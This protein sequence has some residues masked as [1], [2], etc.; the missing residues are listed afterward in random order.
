MSCAI[1]VCVWDVMLVFVW[2]FEH[3]FVFEAR[4]WLKKPVKDRGVD[5][6]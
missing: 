1:C 3:G 4:K 2:I 5:V 6:G